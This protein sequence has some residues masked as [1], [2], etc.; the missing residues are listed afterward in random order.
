M[1]HSD[2]ERECV[3]TV[4]GGERVCT[5]TQLP[6]WA[7]V[8]V[9]ILVWVLRHVT[10]GQENSRVYVMVLGSHAD[11]STDPTWLRD[12]RDLGCEHAPWTDVSL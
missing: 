2:L 10:T 8:A 9:D 5:E 3:L 12:V 4:L 1:D 11:W 6:C 7:C